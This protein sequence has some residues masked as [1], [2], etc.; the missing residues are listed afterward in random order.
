MSW[1]PT[2]VGVK[3]K[4]RRLDQALE[5]LAQ[6]RLCAEDNCL[7]QAEHTAR[8]VGPGLDHP[9]EVGFCDRH[10]SELVTPWRVLGSR[11]LRPDEILDG[12]VGDIDRG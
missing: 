7:E 8:V 9:T 6:G 3:R 11:P 1:N 12:P 10:H 5:W 4:W 2:E